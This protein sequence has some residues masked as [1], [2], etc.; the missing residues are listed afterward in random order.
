MGCRLFIKIQKKSVIFLQQHLV[1][2]YSFFL[3]GVI[4]NSFGIA[5]I[6]KAALGTSPIS[7][8]PYVFSLRFTPTLGQFTFFVNFLF[9]V[10]QIVLLRRE[11]QKIQLLQI[12]VNVLFSSIIDVSMNLL[13]PFAPQGFGQELLW[14]LAGC[15]VLAFG[16]YV[17]VSPKVLMVPGEGL[18][19]AL[20][21]VSGIEFGSVKVAFDV[22]LMSLA[23]IC[24]FLF[25]HGLQGVGLGT[26]I[27]AVLVGLIVKL[28]RRLFPGIARHLEPQAV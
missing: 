5:L 17:E 6:T 1:R 15:A 9:I 10:G 16:I 13:S 18:V 7:S 23:A 28:Y 14:L 26:L 3:L 21:R 27:S 2:R 22:T 12:G 25:F 4:I 8:V 11:F 24:S 20:A 19:S